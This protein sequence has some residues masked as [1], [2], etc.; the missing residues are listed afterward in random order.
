LFQLGRLDNS[1]GP[2]SP[3]EKG[4]YLLEHPTA[5]GVTTNY[6]QFVIL[7]Q[8]AKAAKPLGE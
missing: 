8:E 7:M 6:V 3:F 2:V 4:L 1:N 5:G